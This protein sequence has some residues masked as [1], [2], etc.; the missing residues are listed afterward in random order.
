M[1]DWIGVG[2]RAVSQVSR[3]TDDRVFINSFQGYGSREGASG[4]DAGRN[5]GEILGSGGTMTV[6]V[7]QRERLA[8]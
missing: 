3:V 1:K 2:F 6:D 8:N 4:G 7:K 5:G